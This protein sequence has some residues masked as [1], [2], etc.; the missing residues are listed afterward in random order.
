MKLSATYSRT[1][2]R[3]PAQ[4]SCIALLLAA[5]LCA[6]LVFACVTPFAAFAVLA[7]A[8]L[9]I[10][11]ALAVLATVWLVNQALGFGLLGY[12][13]TADAAMW[14]LAI[15]AAAQLA[16]IVAASVFHRL[17]RL[18]RLFLYPVALAASFA[19]YEGLLWAM[20][21]VLGGA[22]EF[23]LNTVGWLAFLNAAWLAGLVG[24]HELSRF[25]DPHTPRRAAIQT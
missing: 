10:T 13:V 4:W 23:A 14:G 6:S 7:A 19:A 25:L 2:G 15:G 8:V 12:P 3:Q 18:D 24:V 5:A 1:S 17:C 9:P 11:R 20:T 22:D 16:T 21:P